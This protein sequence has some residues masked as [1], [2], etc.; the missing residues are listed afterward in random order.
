MLLIIMIIKLFKENRHKFTKM[1][2]D[3]FFFSRQKIG[4]A[5]KL[6]SIQKNIMRKINLGDNFLIAY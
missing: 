4:K 5:E 2:P 1:L 6:G 3:H